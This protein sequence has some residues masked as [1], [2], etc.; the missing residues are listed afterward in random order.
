MLTTCASCHSWRAASPR[1]SASRR[2]ATSIGSSAF[3]AG[4]TSIGTSA[5]R[6]SAARRARAAYSPYRSEPISSS[7]PISRMSAVTSSLF[8]M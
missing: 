3:A 6:R 4:T 5:D 7:C 2:A 1:Q 8:M